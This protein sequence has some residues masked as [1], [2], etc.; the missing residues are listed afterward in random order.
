MDLSKNL[1]P[2]NYWL[3][4][5]IIFLSVILFI[6]NI[7]IPVTPV[8][9][10]SEWEKIQEKMRADYVRWYVDTYLEP[11]PGPH[12]YIGCFVVVWAIICIC[13]G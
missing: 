9:Q 12:H 11:K 5:L 2:E 8:V 3:P 13:R 1:F 4:G 6:L 7:Y 10:M